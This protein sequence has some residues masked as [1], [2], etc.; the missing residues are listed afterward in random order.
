MCVVGTNPLVSL[1]DQNRTQGGWTGWR[2]PQRSRHCRRG[3][4]V[5]RLQGPEWARLIGFIQSRE[6]FDEW[7][8]VSD[9]REP[10]N[11]QAVLGIVRGKTCTAGLAFL[12]GPGADRRGFFLG[13]MMLPKIPT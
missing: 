2:G 7:R 9:G 8:R 11:I 6:A 3:L 5:A 12:L 13:A 10:V 4:K 1:L